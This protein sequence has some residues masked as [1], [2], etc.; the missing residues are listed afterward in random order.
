MPE[1]L[2]IGRCV[3]RHMLWR[4]EQVVTNRLWKLRAQV[5]QMP[6]QR[7]PRRSSASRKIRSAS[8]ARATRSFESS[9]DEQG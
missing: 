4:D 6:A 2:D 8:S 3:Q 9:P 1:D 7:R 5:V